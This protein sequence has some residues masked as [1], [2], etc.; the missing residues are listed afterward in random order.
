MINYK[1]KFQ[2]YIF[3]RLIT[4]PEKDRVCYRKGRQFFKC[5]QR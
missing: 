5:L 1:A 2:G 3:L 4:I